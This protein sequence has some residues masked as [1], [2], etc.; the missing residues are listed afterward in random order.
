MTVRV[1]IN[2]MGRIGRTFWRVCRTRTDLQVVAVNDLTD[3]RTLAYLLRFDSVHG[4]LPVPVDATDSAIVVDDVPVAAW[5]RPEPGS[6]PW[7]ELGVDVVLEATGRYFAAAHA[8]AHLAAGARRVVVSTATLD[9]DVTLFMGINEH[10]FDARRHSVISPA[11]CTSSAV[12]PPIAA[13]R[14]RFT[15]LGGTLTT[16]HAYDP[17]KS[18]LHDSPHWDRRMGRAAAINLVPARLK[19]GTLHAIGSAF[20]ELAGR[21]DGLHIRV[22]VAIGCAADLVL[23]VDRTVSVEEVNTV[24][25]AAAA[26]PLKNSLDYTDEPIVSSDI[27]GTSASCIVDGQLTTVVDDCVKI[28]GWYDNETG[29]AHRLADVI[30]LVGAE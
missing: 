1:G 9:P 21:I 25:A 15:V 18:V 8:R 23:R 28:I 2:G 19:A 29:F 10:N 4:R 16:V 5:Q 7:G 30:S 17:T 3:P 20:P 6:V 27:V 22:P 13:L 26:G 24:L 14:Q 11:C 12:A